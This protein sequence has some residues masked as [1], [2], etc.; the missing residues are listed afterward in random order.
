M[1]IFVNTKLLLKNQMDGIGWFSY[2]TLKRIT[3][4]HPENQFYFIFDRP[5]NDEFIFSSNIK[6]LVIGPPARHPFLYYLWTEYSLPSLLKK[7]HVDLFIS[8]DGSLPLS[9]TIPSINVIYDLNFEA[10]PQYLPFWYSK[11]YR[12]FFP[13]FAQKATRIATVSEFSKSDIITRYKISS[14]RIEVI[15]AGANNQYSP[16]DENQKQLVRKNISNGK[17]YFLFLSTIHPRKNITNLLTAFDIFK[18]RIKNT[19]AIDVTVK[20]FQLIF[21]GKKSWWTKEMENAFQSM[22]NKKDVIFTGRVNENELKSIVASATGMVYVSFYEGFG[23]PVLEAMYSDVP[24]IT[25]N[26]T[27]LPE[28]A[29][30][31]ALFVDPHSPESIAEALFQLAT[32]SSLR[33]NLIEKGRNQRRKYTWDKTADLFWSCIEKVIHRI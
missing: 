25:S 31:A 9:L 32:D 1:N 14:D 6:P 11:Y 15:Y 20:D 18:I 26:V 17:Q 28:I 27:S 2:E 3:R 8:M 33:Y 29:G 23:M 21:V 22:T 30:D 5:Y 19:S 13:K 7:H 4:N 10:Y 24:I 12:H 16:L